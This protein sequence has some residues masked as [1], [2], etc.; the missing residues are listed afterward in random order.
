MC[1]Y[2]LTILWLALVAVAAVSAF[3]FGWRS[4]RRYYA[5]MGAS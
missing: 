2:H 4:S 3:I 1:M 5:R